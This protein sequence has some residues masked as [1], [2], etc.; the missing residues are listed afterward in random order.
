MLANFL[1]RKLEGRIPL[2]ELVVY[3]KDNINIAL[4]F[5]VAE[6]RNQ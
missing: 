4:I 6:E 1:R 3:F 2:E 5:Y